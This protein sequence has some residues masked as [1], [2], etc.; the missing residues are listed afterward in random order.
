MSTSTRRWHRRSAISL[1]PKGILAEFGLRGHYH[2]FAGR[3]SGTDGFGGKS[4]D[5]RFY[6]RDLEIS[7]AT[8]TFSDPEG[9]KM[10]DDD[11]FR[12][13]M[14]TI[15]DDPARRSGRFWSISI[16][17]IDLDRDQDPRR[18]LFCSAQR[19]VATTQS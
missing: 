5:R 17:K 10:T 13:A 19:Y 8:R 12:L 15:S 1:P 9:K 6:D 11:R 3:Y 18:S 14:R 16:W 7:I 2:A 4:V